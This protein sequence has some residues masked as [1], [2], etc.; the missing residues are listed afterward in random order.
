MGVAVCVVLFCSDSDKESV[1]G[2]C[3]PVSV[4]MCVVSLCV[5]LYC[6]W[7]FRVCACVYFACAVWRC[8]VGICGCTSCLLCT[9]GCIGGVV[10]RCRG[11]CV[12]VCVAREGRVCI[13]V[14]CV[15]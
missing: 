11:E 14:A 10:V 5:L 1:C 2:V 12:C 15:R 3:M 8:G 6:D 13:R 4:C 9:A 7:S